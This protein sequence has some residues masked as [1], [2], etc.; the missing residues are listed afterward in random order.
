[1][2]YPSEAQ[3]DAVRIVESFLDFVAI[4]GIVAQ[5]ESL[6]IARD[7]LKRMLN[8]AED[9]DKVIHREAI[10]YIDSFIL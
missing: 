1:M 6:V 4:T 3:K 10:N 2:G 7:E 8:H 5:R 9:D